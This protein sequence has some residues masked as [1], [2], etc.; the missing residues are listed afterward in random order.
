MS[1][2]HPDHLWSD[3]DQHWMQRA[4]E[5][6][7]SVMAL[8][9]PNPRV[10]CVI[11]RDGRVLGLGATQRAGEA[12][13]E[14]CALR[15]AASQGLAVQGSTVYVTL[16]PCNHHGR[17]PPCVDALIEANPARVVVA[18]PDPNP[19][20]AGQGLER[21]QAAGIAVS[22]G[23]EAEAALAINPGFVARMTRGTPWVWLKLAG[24]LDGRSA[25]HN[26]RSQWITGAAARRDGHAWRA[27][28]CAVLTGIGTVLT[29]D[30]LL[31]PRHDTVTRM[32]HKIVL[33][34]YLRL[35]PDARLLDGTPT[36]VFS[37]VD[38]AERSAALGDRNA[39][40]IITPRTADGRIDLDAVVQWLGN[41]DINEVHVEAG[42]R[43]NGAW[44]RAGL[45]DEL[46]LYQS[47]MLLGDAQPLAELPPA[48][49][50]PE[51]AEFAF[52]DARM[53]GDDLRVRARHI[54]AWAELMRV[55]PEGR[56]T[57]A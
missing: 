32:P 44:L 2:P 39:T 29:D 37:T 7:E 49:V 5:L 42:P 26:G 23:L 1:H 25:L 55:L 31:T 34:T 11:I 28:A 52:I 10:G 46:L 38:D 41:H 48:S 13:A 43:L 56:M 15:D 4:L 16:E 27:R 30:P 14:V 53:L 24:S 3:A 35:P 33:D 12:H 19:Q 45:T 22:L 51:Q 36:W 18:M 47:P 57:N 21:L 8:P 50:L 6:A 20:V 17:T 54:D 40:V 9:S